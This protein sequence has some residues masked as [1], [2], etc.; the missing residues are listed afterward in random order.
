MPASDLHRAARTRPRRQDDLP[1]RPPP[2]AGSAP[3]DLRRPP[4]RRSWSSANTVLSTARTQSSPGPTGEPSPRFVL[5][6]RQ[7]LRPL[8]ARHGRPARPRAS[9]RR[10]TPPTLRLG[11]ASGGVG[12]V[13]GEER[14][15]S[16]SPA[17]SSRRGMRVSS[18]SSKSPARAERVGVEDDQEAGQPRRPRWKSRRSRPVPDTVS[19]SSVGGGCE[20]AAAPAARRLS[21]PQRSRTSAARPSVRVAVELGESTWPCL[22][23]VVC[24]DAVPFA[25]G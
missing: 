11:S 10:L 20:A 12:L 19:R 22:L 7:P 5:E 2:L 9:R 17:R 18:C 1:R 21:C 4:G 8:R 13:A 24:R 25:S 16:G 14:L 15:G 6:P 23:G 3:R